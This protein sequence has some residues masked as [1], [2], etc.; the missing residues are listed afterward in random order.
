MEQVYKLQIV[1]L[2]NFE[3]NTVNFATCT[4]FVAGL[5]QN[6]QQ[7]TLRVLIGGKL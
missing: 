5:L 7:Q 2:L 1:Q 3:I 4:S 6:A